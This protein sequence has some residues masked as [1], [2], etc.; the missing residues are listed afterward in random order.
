VPVVVRLQC[1]RLFMASAPWSTTRSR[2]RSRFAQVAGLKWFAAVTGGAT[3]D[4]N[5]LF[6]M[7]LG[8]TDMVTL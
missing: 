1:R 6:A 3:D 4:K 2:R 5:V 8:L 7:S